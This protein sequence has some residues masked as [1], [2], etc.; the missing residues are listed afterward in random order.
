MNILVAKNGSQLGPF[1][2]KD[3]RAKLASGE[4]SP[5]DYAWHEGMASWA[6]LSQ[7]LGNAPGTLS[8]STPPAPVNAPA[9]YSP[10]PQSSA[11]QKSL[12][13]FSH[14]TPNK[15]QYLESIRT[16][17]AYPTYR[18]II[19]IIAL[20]GYILAGLYGLLALVFGF[21]AMRESFFQG[22]LFI[23]AGFV[24]AALIFL[25]ARFSKEAALILAD[26]GDSVTEANSRPQ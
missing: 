7:L 23:I 19:G 14:M 4:F 10:P 17:T 9:P 2:E 13:N 20:L 6:P 21:I 24:L 18:G 26:I 11:P 16:N 8:P 12:I 1:S 3:V 25:G 22:L 15:E 5:T